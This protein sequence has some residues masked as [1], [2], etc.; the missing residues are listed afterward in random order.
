[1]QTT[2]LTYS[3]SQNNQ[4]VSTVI[5]NPGAFPLPMSGNATYDVFNASTIVATD[6]FV[7][8]GTQELAYAGAATNTF[9]DVYY[10]ENNRSMAIA[11]PYGSL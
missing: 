11:S 3:L 2:N 1:M 9:P 6:T 4:P 5:G 10:Y 8:C 7:R